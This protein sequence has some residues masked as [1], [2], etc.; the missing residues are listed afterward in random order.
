MQPYRRRIAGMNHA[1]ATQRARR[2]GLL[3]PRP[4]VQW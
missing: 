2:Q 3:A 1:D 4:K